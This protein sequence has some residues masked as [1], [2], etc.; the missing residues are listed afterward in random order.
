MLK[1]GSRAKTLTIW[2]LGLIAIVG[3]AFVATKNHELLNVLL[4]GTQDVRPN[5]TAAEAGGSCTTLT[6]HT[7]MDDDVDGGGD[8]SICTADSATA[9]HDIR[10]NMDTPTGVEAISTATN[11]QTFAILARNS[12]TSGTGVATVALDLY[13]NGSL[14]EA[15]AD[16]N[17]GDAYAIVTETFT[18][19]TSSCASDGSDVEVLVDCTA[20]NNGGTNND[21]SCNYEAVEWRVVTINNSP[22]VA[23]NT[24]DAT[25]FGTDTTPTLE[26]TGTDAEDDDV[27][28][29][30]QIDTDSGFESQGGVQTYYFDASDAGPT[31]DDAAW[32]N[33]ANAFD[34]STSTNASVT[35]TGSGPPVTTNEMQAG[36]TNSPTTGLAI[37]QVRARIFASD[38]EVSA[39]WGSYTTLSEPSGGWTFAKV[40]ALEVIIYANEPASVI[41]NAVVFTDGFAQNIGT[42]T[43]TLGANMSTARVYKVE[44][45]VT[46]VSSPLLDKVSGT[47]DGFVN[48]ITGGDTDPFNSGE[49]ASFTVQAGDELSTGTYYWRVRGIDPSGSN[50]YGSFAASRSF[51]VTEAAGE[52]PPTVPDDFII[53]ID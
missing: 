15:G 9:A 19:N 37:S 7:T 39:D 8:A 26:F 29:N 23:L 12:Q 11:A 45:E 30:I 14:V 35:V 13:C 40:A 20:A 43:R 4:G 10:L 36:G 34:G 51:T 38:D 42:A 16:Q 47:D 27:R 44:L 33:D 28:Y 21:T 25:D 22:T 24:A 31:D 18:F 2:A 32:T 49:K 17:L 3:V 52:A 6:A 53:I 41:A 50:A 1:L 5:A 48:T 46:E